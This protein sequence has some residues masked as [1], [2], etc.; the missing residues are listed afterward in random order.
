MEGDKRID[1]LEKQIRQLADEQMMAQHRLEELYNQLK[2]LRTQSSIGGHTIADSDDP[3]PFAQARP[4]TN[5]LKEMPA[6]DG[7]EH[8]IGL[9]LIHLAG[10]IVLLTGISIGIK[11]AIDQELISPL[12]RIGLAYGAGLILLLF[13]WKLRKGYNLFSAIL[14]SGSMACWYFTTY[15]ALAYYGFITVPVAFA[16]MVALTVFT[17]VQSIYYNRIE[18]ALIGLVGAYGIPFLVNNNTGRIDL[19]FSYILLI[20][21]A[22]VFL[23]FRKKWRAVAVL[24]LTI[25]WSLFLGWLLLDGPR[26]RHSMAMFFAVAFYLLFSV[27]ALLRRMTGHGELTPTDR[28]QLIVMNVLL[29]AA[30]VMVIS[31]FDRLP[32]AETGGMCVYIA[33]VA[34]LCSKMLPGEKALHRA[35]LTEA[36]LLLVFFI[37]LK[38]DGIFVTVLW[39]V[40]AVTLFIA[41]VFGKQPWLRVCSVLLIGATLLKLITIDSIRFTAGQRILSFIVIGILLLVGSFYY[42][43]FNRVS[44]T[45]SK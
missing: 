15:G 2:L 21:A 42:Q 10:I 16:L 18:I 39:V 19:F 11:Y 33:V 43:R 28:F 8:F 40:L 37:A 38:W 27:D 45:S 29:Y 30:L 5:T 7:I 3:A 14:F 26:E 25:T 41:G 31:R 13:A 4:A 6:R 20:N 34:W 17:V 22:V 23:A 35:L 24:S 9:R 36:L 44:G 12:A 32:L 1:D